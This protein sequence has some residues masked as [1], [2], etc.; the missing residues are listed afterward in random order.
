MSR[1]SASAA[2]GPADVADLADLQRWFFAAVLEPEAA[3][4]EDV[5]RVIG[6]SAQQSPVERLRVYQRGY[7]LRLLESMRA[8]Y[9]AL[10]H[11]LGPDLF[12]GFACDFLQAYR[13]R[14]Y[15]LLALDERFPD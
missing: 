12:D 8:K 9:P 2:T 4:P 10:R 14:T 11:A 7:V 1:A 5:E 3:T 6:A 15:S 13:S